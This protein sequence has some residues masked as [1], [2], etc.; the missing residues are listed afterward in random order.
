[1]RTIVPAATVLSGL[2][3]CAAAHAQSAKL[4]AVVATDLKAL[5][6]ECTEVGGKAVTTEAVKRVDLNGDG[7]EDYVLYVGWINC[8][9][10]A[11]IY[12]DREMGV[13][14]YVGDGKGGATSA[15]NDSVYGATVEG[16]GPA[17]KLWLTVSGQQCG[18]KP[19][20]N[21]ASENFC[22][23]SIVWNAKTGKFDYAP[24]STVRMIQ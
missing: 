1:M 15:F 17:A 21:F 14:V 20:A 10:A 7:D 18:K 11:S 19:A 16:T 23:R 2:L 4:P 5:A 8:D 24:V 22:S 12:G 9:G 13:T 3:S 6:A